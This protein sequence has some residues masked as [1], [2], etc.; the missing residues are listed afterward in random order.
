MLFLHRETFVYH[1]LVSWKGK[2]IRLRREFLCTSDDKGTLNPGFHIKN[3]SKIV[4]VSNYK[5]SL[6]SAL[7]C[8][9]IIDSQAWSMRLWLSAEVRILYSVYCKLLML[10]GL[11]EVDHQPSSFQSSRYCQS[12]YD[13]IMIWKIAVLF[14]FIVIFLWIKYFPIWLVILG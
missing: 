4:L 10:L 11:P 3:H 14:L 8:S 7:S 5:F 12:D 1:T 2:T 6:A 9:T 13:R